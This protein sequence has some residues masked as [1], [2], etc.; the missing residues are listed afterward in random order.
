VAGPLNQALRFQRLKEFN[1]IG[2]KLGSGNGEILSQRVC[3]LIDRVTLLQQFPIFNP[4]GLRLKQIPCSTSNST[5]PSSEAV[6][7]RSAQSRCLRQ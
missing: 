1:N 3:D 4:T 2:K 5:A 7:G 6:T